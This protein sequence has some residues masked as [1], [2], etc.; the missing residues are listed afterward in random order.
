MNW[1]QSENIMDKF[2]FLKCEE[3]ED[4]QTCAWIFW[5]FSRYGYK[6]FIFTNLNV[7]LFVR[8]DTENRKISSIVLETRYW[9]A[10]GPNFGA[11]QL[12]VLEISFRKGTNEE[13]HLQRSVDATSAWLSDWK[14]AVNVDK[15]MSM[16]FT[17]RP[18]SSDFAINLNGNTLKK[19]RIPIKGI[20]AWSLLQTCGGQHTSTR[21]SPKRPDSCTPWNNS[22][23]LSL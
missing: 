21:C 4:L 14:L 18:F 20:S 3:E 1:S 5:M 13:G 23:V 22:V 16:E 15:A 6:H 9:W 19:V 12:Y 7:F 11:F 10:V 17:R 8:K 2:S